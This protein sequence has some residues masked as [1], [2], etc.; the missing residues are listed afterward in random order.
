MDVPELI[1]SVDIVEYI[2][3]FCELEPDN[4][5]LWGLSPLKEENTPSFSVNKEKQWFKDFSSG[6]GGNIISFIMCYFNCDYFEAVNILKKY[7]GENNITV[8]QRQHL[9]A[10]KI[11]KRYKVNKKST[12]DKKY[13]ILADN[14]MDR[15]VFDKDK[16]QIWNDEGIA[17]ETMDKF[18]VKYDD[19]SNRIVLPIR[20][21]NGK[22][23]NVCGRTLDK[24]YKQKKLPKYIYY[25][26]MGVLDTLYGFYEN[27]EAALEKEEVILFEGSKSVMIADTWGIKNT[28]AIL[29]SHLN[30]QQMLI[31]IKLGIRVVFA[32]DE[33][34]D[35]NEDK[36]I[37]Q[38]KKYVKIENVRNFDNILKPKMAPVDAGK[39]VWE[40]LY[41]R[42]VA[43]N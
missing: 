6:A 20:D 11:A 28:M 13:T 38:L 8:N 33:E 5:E 25:K 10:A 1:K 31:L 43:V 30:V 27:I 15:Y 39:A 22:I 36:Y 40:Q 24:D 35:I 14:Y 34:V 19:F 26:P 32:L 7:A 17:W 3:Q 16:L 9:N 41:E 12:K 18:Q 2:S 21:V 4:G 23:I 37:Q 42:R 29:T